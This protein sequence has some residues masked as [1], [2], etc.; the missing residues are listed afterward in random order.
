MSKKHE[1]INDLNKTR[2]YID[3]LFPN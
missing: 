2:K 1:Q 3:D